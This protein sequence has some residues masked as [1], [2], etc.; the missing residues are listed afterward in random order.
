MGGDKVVMQAAPEIH[1]VVFY[2]AQKKNISH[3]ERGAMCNA[4]CYGEMFK[5]CV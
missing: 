4:I 5:T 1:N 2:C 3:R